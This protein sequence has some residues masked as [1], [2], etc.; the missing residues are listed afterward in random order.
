MGEEKGN[1]NIDL[2]DLEIYDPV[3]CTDLWNG[4]VAENCKSIKTELPPHGAAAF[5]L[6]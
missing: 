4:D 2:A 6:K 1:L 3:T 5:L